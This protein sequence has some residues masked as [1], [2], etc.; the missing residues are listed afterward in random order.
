MWWAQAMAE[1]T[2][3]PDLADLF[4]P[5]ADALSAAEETILQELIECQGKPMDI[6]GYYFPDP[7]LAAEAMRPSSTFNQIVDGFGVQP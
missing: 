7:A 2:D 5:L 4:G 1:Q 6:G 3:D